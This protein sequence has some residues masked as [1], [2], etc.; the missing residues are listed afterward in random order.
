M[1][2]QEDGVPQRAFEGGFQDSRGIVWL[3]W[4]NQLFRF[5]GHK[6][7]RVWRNKDK[8]YDFH[9][10]QFAEDRQHN[11]WWYRKKRYQ[12]T[13]TLHI[14]APREDKLYTLKE[15]LGKDADRLPPSN[16]LGMFSLNQ[17]VYLNAPSAG[18]LWQYADTL[19][20]LI[21][22]PGQE[23][24]PRKLFP[25]P[26]GH[27][28]GLS[29]KSGIVL[30]DSNGGTM[31]RYPQLNLDKYHFSLD[32]DFKLYRHSNTSGLQPVGIPD[33]LQ[34]ITSSDKGQRKLVDIYDDL[35]HPLPNTSIHLLRSGKGPLRVISNNEILIE[36]L[37][38]FL[39]ERMP[40]L[41]LGL[42]DTPNASIVRLDDGTILLPT[43]DRGLV[44]L[45]ISPSYFRTYLKGYN[46]RGLDTEGEK[47]YAVLSGL[48]SDLYEVDLNGN[49]YRT[50]KKSRA[51]PNYYYDLLIEDNLAFITLGDGQLLQTPL[52]SKQ[53]GATLMLGED[54]SVDGT[55][56]K[57]I[58][59]RPDSLV[60]Y[61]SY[62]GLIEVDR[63]TG[64]SRYLMEDVH[65]YWLHEDQAGVAWAGTNR[66]I[67]NITEDTYY[68][69]DMPNGGAV[70]VAHI[71]E[72]D[73]QNFWLST[74]QGLIRWT[75]YTNDYDHYTEADGL[76]N[77]F[78]HAVYPDQSGRLW[79]SS[80]N[81]ILSFDLKTAK[82]TPYF[83]TDG[84]CSDEQNLISHTQAPDGR[85][86]F[87]SINGINSFYPDSMPVA[88]ASVNDHFVVKKLNLYDANGAT[89]RHMKYLDEANMPI[90][91]PEACKQLSV[92]LIIPYFGFQRLN[93]EWRIP[94]Q[95][96]RWQR[97]S[98]D[99][100][101]FLLSLPYGKFD[102]EL[103]AWTPKN[104]NT[105][106]LATL[107]FERAYPL[108]MYPSFWGA[109]ILLMAGVLWLLYRWRS[110]AMRARNR[111][112]TAMVQQR[113]QELETQKDKILAQNKKLEKVDATKNQ[114]FNNI[115]HELRS[116]LTLIQVA[117]E[118]LTKGDR[119]A[120]ARTIKQQAQHVTQ[121]IGDIMNLSKIELGMA[122]L[123]TKP[124]E[125]NSLLQQ[126]FSMFKG[127]AER[128]QQYY[129]LHLNPNDAVYLQVDTEKM[130]SIL[131]NL[132]GNALK[133]TPEG[134]HVEVHSHVGDTEIT[135]LVNDTGPGI[136]ED[137]QADIFKRYFQGQASDG[138]AEPGY[139]IGLAL[140]K[141]YTE[142]MGG[143]IDVE[144]TPQQGTSFIV[145]LPKTN[146]TVLPASSK[147]A[148]TVETAAA[149]P[150]SYSPAAAEKDKPK[151]LIAEDNEQILQLLH[152]MLAS[153]Y[154][155]RLTTN[156]QA[157]LEALE[158]QP[159]AYDVVISDIMMPVMD[160]YTLLQ[161]TRAHPK[162]GFTP[163]LMLTALASADDRLKALRLGVD[164]FVTKP[165]ETLELKTRI[166][167]LVDKQ[168][169]RRAYIKEQSAIAKLGPPSPA[170]EAELER[171]DEAWLQ[172]LEATVRENLPRPEFKVTDLAFELH[173]SE[174]TLRNYIK[175]YTGMPPSTYLQKARL[176]QALLY[177]KGKKYK[178]VGEVAY[179]VGFKNTRY[180][181]KLFK[182]T[183]GKT[184]SAYL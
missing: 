21:A 72:Q 101:V 156:G 130:V 142:L 168:Q 63:A 2:T 118:Q 75:P 120:L 9:F 175:T 42:S 67:Y 24:T 85:L 58:F 61:G 162:L 172:K 170:V 37:I 20:Q 147:P 48:P 68:L 161:K 123:K 111:E 30:L 182:Q 47:L 127:L 131:N 12:P 76:S 95:S 89:I 52:E 59:L 126:H 57:C 10:S 54:T 150:P 31:A 8:L 165:F 34:H 16:L 1:W 26:H 125:W 107:S 71:C 50:T 93:L 133:Y 33:S 166:K 90:L 92:D 15:Y 80:N 86:L 46:I 73:P 62:Q 19:E 149:P 132:I 115:S 5:D 97:V 56:A 184:P 22:S 152:K 14:Y 43:L 116:P 179:A 74:H 81:G 183:H 99:N 136:P 53:L 96:E 23:D 146:A 66:G 141:E 78:L 65:V 104:M 87:G 106:A 64:R 49:S 45:E 171:Y 112:L 157:A 135:L 77:N 159:D 128:K 79:I 174:R 143:N 124:V 148:A 11:I 119:D 55:E 27:Y 178:T 6:M 83:T 94:S 121:M 17:T 138:M 32:Q 105:P 35:F 151:I 100:Q 129:Q 169:L 137:E 154:Q 36:D 113:T 70:R 103:R 158:A 163:F 109:A 160:G 177:L 91:L 28:W 134:G 164:A 144:S 110:R 39:Q 38:A 102:M 51:V 98:E 13:A 117:A 84:L 60:W 180:F 44:Q 167:G 181:S 153:D 18:R 139:G 173:V 114:L 108:Y 25:A 3:S 140:C 4:Q 122:K 88:A 155:V 41:K 176:D 29:R 69:D 40:R 145:R 82:F 7:V